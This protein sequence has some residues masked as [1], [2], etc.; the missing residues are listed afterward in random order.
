ML[1]SNDTRDLADI[2][3]TI[4]AMGSEHWTWQ[5]GLIVGTARIDVVGVWAAYGY[6]L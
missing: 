3:A 5:G 2:R 1:Q 4:I 6:Y